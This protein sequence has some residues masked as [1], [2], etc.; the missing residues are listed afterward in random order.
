MFTNRVAAI[1]VPLARR[2]FAAAT[3]GR[4]HTNVPAGRAYSSCASGPAVNKDRTPRLAMVHPIPLLLPRNLARTEHWRCQDKRVRKA[5]Q[6]MDQRHGLRNEIKRTACAL[7]CRRERATA[8]GR[9]WT[10]SLDRPGWRGFGEKHLYL[11]PSLATSYPSRYLATK[12]W[13]FEM[14]L[15][16]KGPCS[17]RGASLLASYL[18]PTR[19][20]EEGH[21]PVHRTPHP[22]LS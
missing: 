8:R 13:A 21:P 11:Y 4:V 2:H 17:P 1:L 16:M 20:S 19:T 5:A 9:K 22:N 18:H 7:R 3:A 15:P 10:I 12:S 14:G 6:S